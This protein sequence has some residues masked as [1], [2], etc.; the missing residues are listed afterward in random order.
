M[1]RILLSEYRQKCV[2]KTRN[3]LMLRLDFVQGVFFNWASPLD[4]AP[5]KVL[6]LAPPLNFLSVGITFTSPDT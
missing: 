5:P 4:W 2:N 1:P 6:R 3:I